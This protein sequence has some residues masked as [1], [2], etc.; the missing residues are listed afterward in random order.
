M[1]NFINDLLMKFF[2]RLATRWFGFLDLYC[3]GDTTKAIIMAV[4]EKTYRDAVR[5]AAKH[6][7]EKEA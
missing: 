3:P 5:S 6:L 1:S 4:D 2:V 7:V